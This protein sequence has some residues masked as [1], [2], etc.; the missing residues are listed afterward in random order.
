MAQINERIKWLEKAISTLR[1][2]KAKDH[3][4][5]INRIINICDYEEELEALKSIKA[6]NKSLF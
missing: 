1:N 3:N 6:S 2:Y 4:E 5:E